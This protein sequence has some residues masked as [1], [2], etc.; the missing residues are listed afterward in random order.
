MT[1]A[2]QDYQIA[3]KEYV[4]SHRLLYKDNKFSE[5]FHGLLKRQIMYNQ[6]IVYTFEY[7][8][9]IEL[10]LV[11]IFNKLSNKGRVF[12]NAFNVPEINLIDAIREEFSPRNSTFHNSESVEQKSIYCTAPYLIFILN[13]K[14]T[15]GDQTYNYFNVGKISYGQEIDISCLVEYPENKNRY[16]IS[17]IIKEKNIN[18]NINNDKSEN[19]INN[20]VDENGQFYYYENKI[21]INGIFIKEG[22]YEHVLIYKQLKD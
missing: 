20:N 6:N 8:S 7:F 21:T 5:L 3:L 15:V 14:K 11:D 18:N 17:S 12:Y 10:N 4:E 19:Y 2:N 22:Y 9:Y 16:R 13:S 1:F